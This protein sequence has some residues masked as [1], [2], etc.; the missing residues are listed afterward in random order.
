LKGKIVMK[1]TRTLGVLL[2]LTTMMTLASCGG[3]A[4][5]E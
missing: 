2:S 3:D 4:K 5:L 1:N